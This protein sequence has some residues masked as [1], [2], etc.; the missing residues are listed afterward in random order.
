MR[1]WD[2]GDLADYGAF[3]RPRRQ[4]LQGMESETS[5]GSAMGRRFP[6]S[7][8]GISG[9][10]TPHLHGVA[11]FDAV[12]QGLIGP[13]IF[14]VP[15]LLT[16]ARCGLP[17]WP[18]NRRVRCSFPPVRLMRNVAGLRRCERP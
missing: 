13:G 1:H 8:V 6:C 2:R 5:I 17:R 4:A 16:G 3:P 18:E 14:R 11:G 7:G 15:L 10:F 12:V 9:L